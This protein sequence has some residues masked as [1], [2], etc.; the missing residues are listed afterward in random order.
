MKKITIPFFLLSIF[1]S[2]SVHA[3]INTKV[4]LSFEEKLSDWMDEFDVPA[5]G[6]GIIENGEVIYTKVF[7]EL[8]KGV[9]AP[10]DAIFN[11]GSVTK[12][13]ITM[14][15][16]KLIESGSWDLDEPLYHYWIDPDVA[17]DPYHKIITTRHVLTHQSGFLNW[18]GQHPTQRL[19]FE[20]EPGTDYQYSG[21]GFGY[22]Q[23]ALQN[24]FNKSIV[25]LID[26]VLF[27]PLDL[28]DCGLVWNEST[29]KVRFANWHD[30]QGNLLDPSTPIND[31][32]NAWGSMV[33]S[34]KDLCIIG[35]DVING[36]GLSND[37]NKEMNKNQVVIDEHNAIG[38]GWFKTYNLTNGEYTL[39][40]A[41]WRGGVKSII[42]L[43]PESKRGIVILTNS[44]NG[45]IVYQKII[46]EAFEVGEEITGYV[47]GGKKRNSINLPDSTLT[48]Y[49]G[50]YLDSYGRDITISKHN[51]ALKFSGV[52]VPTLIIYPESENN[53]YPEEFNYKLEFSK[54]KSY[55]LWVGD[56]ID[57]T[58]TKKMEDK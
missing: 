31:F 10:N 42:I 49:V 6:I 46:N 13:V 54:Y 14:L 25:D 43:L 23:N 39:H 22:L 8:K 56:K 38:L 24:K 11:L 36:A 12:P 16:L 33:S 3:Q 20:F 52:G 17:D 28:K 27:M 53:F 34:V 35:A 7:G 2:I 57:C 5:V 47:F 18:R 21:E 50:V 29:D 48:K 30:S 45:V 32:P 26:S 44:D 51:N 4:N 55:K 15:T 37:L 9:P 58:A 1:M 41:G 40:H 19:I